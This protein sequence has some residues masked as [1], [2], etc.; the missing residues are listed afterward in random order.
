MATATPNG[1]TFDGLHSYT[2]FG[3]WLVARPDTG[4]PQP[5]LNRVE[6]PGMDG[7]IDMTEVNAGDV[8]FY[9]RTMVFR[10]AGKV[11]ISEQAA[12]KA[13]I[14]DA[15]HGKRIEKIILDEDSLWYYSGRVTVQ[16]PEAKP[17]KIYCTITVDADPYAMYTIRHVVG[18]QPSSHT[19]EQQ[20]VKLADDSSEMDYDSDFLLG[21]KVF[22]VGF[23]SSFGFTQFS[24]VWDTSVVWRDMLK[25]IDVYDSNDHQFTKIVSP[26]RLDHS[27]SVTFNELT[28][29][30][31][32]LTKV[33]RVHIT[34]IGGGTLT[35]EAQLAH[36]EA[37]NER[38]P[39]VP[40]FLLE[41]SDA[42]NIMVNG[43]VFEI[44]V[45][46]YKDAKIMLHSGVNDIYIGENQSANITVFGMFYRGGK[47]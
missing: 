41:A 8:K 23:D 28:Q 7:I 18:L 14:M 32:D 33:Y 27:V 12:F 42:V 36:I 39:V 5:K 43:E 25:R 20:S 38:K 44:P 4:S 37:Q 29:D 16:F 47:L 21:T 40:E 24:I 10:F 1:I 26:S 30:G 13:K 9:N 11:E 34:G 6:V 3:L 22:P 35:T 46:Y 15:L 17:W 19:I 45:G 31:I 2:D